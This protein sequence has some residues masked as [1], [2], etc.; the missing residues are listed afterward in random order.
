MIDS[1][2]CRSRGGPEGDQGDAEGVSRQT[3]LHTLSHTLRRETTRSVS[4]SA[5]LANRSLH[6]FL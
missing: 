2:A 6:K 4:D 3:Q 5:V 1:V